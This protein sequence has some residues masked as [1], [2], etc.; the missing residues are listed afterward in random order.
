MDLDA[1][2]DCAAPGD[3]SGCAKPA[4][5]TRSKRSP[6]GSSPHGAADFLER[7]RSKDEVK[8]WRAARS[9]R[10]ASSTPGRS[11]A[12]DRRRSSRRSAPK[13]RRSSTKPSRFAEES[14]EPSLDEVVHGCR[15][16]EAPSR[17]STRC[18]DAMQRGAQSCQAYS[19]PL[20]SC[21]PEGPLMPVMTYREALRIAMA[22]EME[23]DERRAHGRGHR[24]LRRHPSRSPTACSTVRPQARDRHADRRG[25][26]HRRRDRDGDDRA[27]GRSSR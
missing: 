3:R 1:V 10:A 19:W 20:G 7:Y 13:P 16:C 12:V 27:C 9:D 25:R 11:G 24:R 4:S 5:R 15:M 8:E 14:P 18:T 6:T 26:L 23:R 17:L 22:E 2:I 21:D